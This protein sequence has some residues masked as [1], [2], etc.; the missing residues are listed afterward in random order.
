MQIYKKK[1]TI[2]HVRKV[3]FMPLLYKCHLIFSSAV[4]LFFL[5]VSQKI[6]PSL[7]AV[8]VMSTIFFVF[9]F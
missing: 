1:H 4:S 5:F 3:N 2:R 6:S 7:P 8:E 9:R